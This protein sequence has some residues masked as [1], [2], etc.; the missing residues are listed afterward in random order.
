MNTKLRM[1]AGTFLAAT[2]LIVALCLPSAFAKGKDEPRTEFKG[3]VTAKPHGT[4]A[5]VWVIDGRQIRTSPDT[6]FD[7]AE[8]P[9][10]VGACVRVKVR[11]GRIHEIDSEPP[12]SCK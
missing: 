7:Q 2:V 9:L 8:G 12:N 5:G 6:Q 1:L 4:L 10:A 3:I 11:N